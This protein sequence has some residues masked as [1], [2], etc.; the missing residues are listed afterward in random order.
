MTGELRF[1]PDGWLV[2]GGWWPS[3][4][5]HTLVGGTAAR[6]ELCAGAATTWIRVAVGV[7]PRRTAAA[8]WKTGSAT[9]PEERAGPDCGRDVGPCV[10]TNGAPL[11]A[12]AASTPAQ[13]AVAIA[14]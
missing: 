3:G 10:L 6:A 5:A 8:R 7:P 2:R 9:C 1:G 13:A 4:A 11:I 14:L 12:V